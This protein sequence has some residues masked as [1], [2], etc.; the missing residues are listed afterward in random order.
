MGGSKLYLKKSVEYTR[1][2]EQFGKPISQFG[3]IK[4]KLANCAI[5]T[6]INE[7]VIHRS[8]GLIDLMLEAIGENDPDYGKKA[9]QGIH[10]YAIECAI[11]KVF[12]SETLAYIVDESVQMLGGYGFIDEYPAE[13]AYRD[14]RIC[15]I[16][17]GTNEICRMIVF[18]D[19]MR[20]AMK[21]QLPLMEAAMNL[22]AEI[23]NPETKSEPLADTPLA[24]QEHM[25][26]MC[27]KVAI[28]VTGA[29]VN[30]FQ[31]ELTN[32]QEVT[33]RIADII[34]ETFAMESGLLRAQKL[35]AGQGDQAAKYHIAMTKSF[36]DEAVGKIENWAKAA[37]AHIEEGDALTGQIAA[38]RRFLRYTPI[39]NIALK[40]T[41]A[42]R[43][44]ETG[45]YPV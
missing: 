15:R 6:Y 16:Y 7:S 31:M 42:D 32:Q 36:V 40:R 39:D 9:A 33:M 2:R 35:I 41:I 24:V 22:A 34:I 44:I 20:K 4:E 37:L 23:T 43:V 3:A 28:M 5:K 1:V 30:K 38:L 27:K 25:V 29:A 12:G 14:A 11:D 26:E 18:G 45:G 10:E 17:E 19:L 8:A 21:G 13:R